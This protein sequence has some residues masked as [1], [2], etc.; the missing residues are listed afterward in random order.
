MYV[1]GLGVNQ[2]FKMAM[3]YYVQSANQGDQ[4]AQYNIGISNSKR[5]IFN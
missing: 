1:K 5:N 3:N 2:D 4:Y